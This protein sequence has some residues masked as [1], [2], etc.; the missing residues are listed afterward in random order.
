MTLTESDSQGRKGRLAPPSRP[1]CGTRPGLRFSPVRDV[2]CARAWPPSH[3][4]D[5]DYLLPIFTKSKHNFSQSQVWSVL[6]KIP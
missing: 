6:Q 2:V 4:V 3:G 5:T 1:E